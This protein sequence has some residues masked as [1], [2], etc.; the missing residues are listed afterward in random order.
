MKRGT[1]FGIFIG[2]VAASSL[3]AAT[4][5]VGSSTYPYGRYQAGLGGEFTLSP[6]DNSPAWLD[7]SGYAPEVLD[8]GGITGSFQ[9]FCLEYSEHIYP[10]S[11]KFDISI[12]TS[13]K[14]G[15]GGAI[16]GADRLSKGTGWLYSR[17]AQG[18]LQ[19]YD[20]NTTETLREAD[21][22]VLQNAI[23]VLEDE[24]SLV[25]SNGYIDLVIA[26]FGSLAN[27]KMDGAEEFGVYAL[28]MTRLSNN[29][30]AQ[31]QL[32]YKPVPDLGSTALLMAAGF[33]GLLICRRRGV[34]S[35]KSAQALSV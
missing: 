2:A 17:F 25:G 9:T 5:Q 23:W 12:S 29:T 27:A 15:G 8:Q 34:A 6:L 11:A 18:I 10:F 30:K 28:N 3:M 16:S 13:A 21:A 14:E 33:G 19:G 31:D 7:L 1:V 35:R 4:V 24:R 20:Y 32:Y 22:I 26:H